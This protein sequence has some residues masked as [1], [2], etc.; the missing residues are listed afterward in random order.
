LGV[1]YGW[2]RHGGGRFEGGGT[3]PLPWDST[4]TKGQ[5]INPTFP[6]GFEDEI[7]RKICVEQKKGDNKT[8]DK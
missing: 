3:P 5:K 6:S 1:T 4:Q 8:S 7:K 2:R